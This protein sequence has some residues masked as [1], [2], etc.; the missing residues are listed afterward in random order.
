MFSSTVPSGAIVC[1]HQLDKDKRS[2]L[3][4]NWEFG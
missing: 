3:D 1:I 4:I 2:G